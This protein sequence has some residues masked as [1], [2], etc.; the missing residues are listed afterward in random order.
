MHL[1]QVNYPAEH[2]KLH[3]RALQE[4]FIWLCFSL[5]IGNSP[6][7]FYKVRSQWLSS[8]PEKCP[9]VDGLQMQPPL[10]KVMVCVCLFIYFGLMSAHDFPDL[11]W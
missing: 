4:D 11:T 7:Y 8:S 2:H 6:Q 1:K 5:T 3:Q 9:S 10:L